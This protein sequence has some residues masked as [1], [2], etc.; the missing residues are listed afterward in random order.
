MIYFNDNITWIT[1]S[2]QE[3]IDKMCNACIEEN[4]KAR[5]MS[6]GKYIMFP[7]EGFERIIKIF[8]EA[9]DYKGD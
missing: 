9:L 1:S 4:E 7:Y 6:S 8:Y 2:R 5:H 3:I